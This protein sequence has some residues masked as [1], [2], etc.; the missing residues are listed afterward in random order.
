MLWIFHRRRYAHAML[1]RLTLAALLLTATPAMAQSVTLMGLGSSSCGAWTAAKHPVPSSYNTAAPDIAS[2]IAGSRQVQWLLG[3]LSGA[4][5]WRAG[6]EDALAGTELVGLEA[7]V[8]NYCAQ[9]PLDNIHVAA[10]AL[11]R[12]LLD[13]R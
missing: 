11:M 7:W 12:E 5:I 8:S 3:Y 1:L 2:A 9:N 10:H 6:S 13:R 4:N